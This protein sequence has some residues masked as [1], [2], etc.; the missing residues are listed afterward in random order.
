MKN[1]YVILLCA[2]GIQ[3][4][5]ISFLVHISI[6]QYKLNLQIIYFYNDLLLFKSNH[7]YHQSIIIASVQILLQINCLKFIKMYFFFI[8]YYYKT[9]F[10]L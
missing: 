2:Y 9:K 10:Q 7:S 8:L 4:L 1:L 5:F 3:I 6:P